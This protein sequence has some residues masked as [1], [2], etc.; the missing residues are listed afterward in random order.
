MTVSN[1]DP[2]QME[3]I[4]AAS[5]GTPSPQSNTAK[6]YDTAFPHFMCVVVFVER[7]VFN[8]KKCCPPITE[9]IAEEIADP[10][11]QTLAR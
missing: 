11:I 9:F 1:G 7:N 5:T 8:R 3:S 6:I 10:L 4:P 2:I